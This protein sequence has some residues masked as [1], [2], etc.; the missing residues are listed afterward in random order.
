[1]AISLIHLIHWFIWVLFLGGVI[2]AIALGNV[3]WEFSQSWH[4]QREASEWYWMPG[5]KDNRG[6]GYTDWAMGSYCITQGSVCEWV[7]LLYNRTWWNIVNQLY[8]NNK[9]I[10]NKPKFKNNQT[11]IAKLGF[12][13]LGS[14]LSYS[15]SNNVPTLLPGLLCKSLSLS[16]CSESALDHFISVLLSWIH[17][18]LSKLL[19]I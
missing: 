14:C 2:G 4:R 3:Q 13:K 6:H 19:K 10:V 15:L 18:C 7:T 9:K 16:F 17:L 11:Q 8:F 12:P 5:M 1:M